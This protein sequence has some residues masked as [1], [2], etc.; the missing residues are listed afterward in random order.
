MAEKTYV[1]RPAELPV[2]DYHRQHL[3]QGTF[4]RNPDGSL[5]TFYGTI[6]GNDKE[7]YQ[8][9]PTYWH[10]DIREV[11]DAMAFAEKSGIKFPR[12]KSLTQAEAAER[13]L[14]TLMEEDTSAFMAKQA[15][16]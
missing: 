15:K 3:Q 4:R 8:I 7:G 1:P 5:T 6:V 9:I 11:P 2:L 10:G 12:Y 16:R 13:A 14:H